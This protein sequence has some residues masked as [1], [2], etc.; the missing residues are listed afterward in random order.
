MVQ[1]HLTSTD[2]VERLSEW[3]THLTPQTLSL[4]SNPADI[5]YLTGFRFLLP[6]EREAFLT[7]TTSEV[8]LWHAS[9]SPLPPELA[10]EAKPMKGFDS[11]I[12]YLQSNIPQFQ[13][14]QIEFDAQNLT[15]AEHQKLVG[16]KNYQ[17]IALDRTQFWRG[18]IKKTAKEQSLLHQVGQLSAQA[19]QTIQSSL[20]PGV[21][22][23]EVAWKLTNLTHQ[24]GA[25]S[26]A[27]PTIVAF[28]DHTALPHHQPTDRVLTLETPILLD[29]G[30]RKEGY[31]SDLTRTWW[32]GAQPPA[33]FDKIKTTVDQAYR[34]TV[35][36]MQTQLT[37][38]QTFTAKDVDTQARTII[39]QAGYGRQFVHTTG[40]GVGLDVHEPPSLNWH[41]LE[42]IQLETCLTIEPGIYLPGKFGYRYE[43][44]LLVT[45]P[46][47]TILTLAPGES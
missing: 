13:L 7:I 3:Q 42:K 21:T 47:L 22:E 41:N 30:A 37:N 28:G 31:C 25:E 17:L 24:A 12:E 40:H 33:E 11:I 29:F 1:S 6:A 19:I 2:F 43:N 9:F 45:Q 16:L 35:A 39:N 23:L 15:V 5:E 44:S 26:L 36:W 20:K 34:T 18:R 32:F 10:V 14:H 38:S 27:F 46:A 4:L 8:V